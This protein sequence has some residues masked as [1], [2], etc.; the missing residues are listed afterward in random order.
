[1]AISVSTFGTHEG[2]RVDQFRLESDTGSVVEIIGFGVVVRDWQVPV[3]GG[4]RGVVL[5]L[6]DLDAY[7][8]HSPHLGAIAGRV[9]NRI[10]GSRFTLEGKTYDL[11][12]NHGPNSLHGGPDGLGRQV[13]QGETDEA[14]NSVTFT[15]FSP[16]GHMGYPG[17]VTFTAKYTLTGN[18]LRLDLA[19]DA[20]RNTP[21]SLVQHQYF[22]L[23]TTDT[24]LDHLYRFEASAYTEVDEDLIPS[25]AILPVDGTKWDFRDAK[26]M[27]DAG[28]KPI[29]YDGN[30]VLDDRH[31]A[32]KPVAVVKSP[33]GDLTL[34]FWTDRPGLQV[35]NGVTTD[36]PVPGLNG[37]HYGQHSGFCL[38][39]QAFPDALHRPYFPN[40][41]YGPDRP[42]RHWCEIE[43]G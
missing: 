33:E 13:W 29:E 35:Y 4:R 3:Q 15:H 9:A 40:I 8:E 6:N 26:T 18:R 14:A 22:N 1:M 27:R 24:V 41:I 32:A 5:G 20:D 11:V 37:K 34:Q 38:E 28:G 2:K 31:D 7:V 30:I 25:G 36:I 43:I 12:A 42:Y 17:N 10:A 39:D 19:A 21:I 16:D 23:G